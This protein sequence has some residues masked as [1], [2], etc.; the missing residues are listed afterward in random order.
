LWLRGHGFQLPAH[1]TV[2]HRNSFVLTITTLADRWLRGDLIE[3]YK[4]I[5]GKEKLKI[6]DFFEFSDTGYNL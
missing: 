1:S 5:T 6:G 4:I 3:V 2:L